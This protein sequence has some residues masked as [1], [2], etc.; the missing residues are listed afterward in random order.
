YVVEVSTPADGCVATS[1]PVSID[2]ADEVPL[3][4]VIDACSDPIR[5]EAQGGETWLWTGPGTINTPTG[6]VTTVAD[7]PQGINEFNLNVKQTGYCDLD[8]TVTVNV[9]NNVVANFT[10]SDECAD[11]VLLTATPN[12]P[13]TYRWYRDGLLIPGGRVLAVGPADHGVNYRV[14]VV[15]AVTGC[16]FPS[17]TKT[18]NVSGAL[19]LTLAATPPCEGQPFTLTAT[20]NQTNVSYTWSLDGEVLPGETSATIEET[21]GG[22]YD[23]TATSANGACTITRN[24][25]V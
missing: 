9:N 6:A 24:F 13:Y 4:L 23:V 22:R 7:L 16:I 14:E 18:V 2:L 10:Q 25:N 20:A 19:D 5:L 11:E 15:N 17:E 8:T 21:R 3:T 12:G 1:A